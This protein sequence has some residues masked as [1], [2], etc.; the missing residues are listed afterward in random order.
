[1]R[2]R[3][4]GKVWSCFVA[5]LVKGKIETREG[6]P[7]T[8]KLPNRS[9]SGDPHLQIETREGSPTEEKEEDT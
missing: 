6:S 7:T 5:R 1:M 8:L 3:G 4:Y 2:T 9:G